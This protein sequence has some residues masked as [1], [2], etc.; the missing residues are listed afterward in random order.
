[1]L[2]CDPARAIGGYDVT[3]ICTNTQKWFLVSATYGCIS[4]IFTSILITNCYNT[5]IFSRKGID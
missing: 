4:C 1:M 3:R 5:V 2:E